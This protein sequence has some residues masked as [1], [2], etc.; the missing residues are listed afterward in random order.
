MNE[1][2]TVCLTS[3]SQD[4]RA[5]GRIERQQPYQGMAVFVENALAGQTVKAEILSEKKNFITARTVEV[6][7]QSPFA[8]DGICIHRQECGGCSWQALRYERQ[9][10]EKENLLKNVLR[11]VG[12]IDDFEACFHPLITPSA[13]QA[14]TLFYRN[15][16]EFAFSLQNNRL[17]LGLRKKNSHDIVEVTECKLQNPHAMKILAL[18]RTVLKS[19]QHEF[20]RYAVLRYFQDK[21]TVELITYPFSKNNEH[22]E[23]Q[24]VLACYEALK[25]TVSGMVHSVRTSKTDVAY[26]ENI[27]CEYGDSLLFEKLAMPKHTVNFKLG[28]SAFFQVNTAMAE[29]LYRVIYNFAALVLPKNNAHIWDCYCGVGA[30]ALSLA[31]LA[32]E[33]KKEFTLGYMNGISIAFPENS[34]KKPFVLGVEAVQKAIALAKEN[35][36]LNQCAFAKFECSAGKELHKYFARF[37]LPNLIILDPPRAGVEDEALNA[38]FEYC[39]QFLILVSCNPAT[40]ARDLAKLAGKYSV[41]AIQGIDL[42]PHTPHVETV[43]L[44]EKLYK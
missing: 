17:K 26:G 37:S 39:P 8:A 36:R 43:V 22:D 38:I 10:F 7:E 2:L 4:G 30:I 11:R 32:V 33:N 44:L 40:L 20:Y 27:V 19:F 6:I 29:Q 5:V 14:D 13:V 42:F 3:M 18:L 16:M 28:N 9:V 12:K 41:K 23:K 31:P 21:W 24:S 15:K 35:A 25:H 1:Y 34:Y